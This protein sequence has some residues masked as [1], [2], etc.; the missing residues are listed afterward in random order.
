[1]VP[2]YLKGRCLHEGFRLPCDVHFDL[3]MAGRY[4]R[5]RLDKE[6]DGVHARDWCRRVDAAG[7]GV[8]RSF[9]LSNRP[10]RGYRPHQL[11][12]RNSP[13][14]T[15]SLCRPLS[16]YNNIQFGT[17]HLRQGTICPELPDDGRGIK[18]P[19]TIETRAALKATPAAPGSCESLRRGDGHVPETAGPTAIAGT[20]GREGDCKQWPKVSQQHPSRRRLRRRRRRLA[21]TRPLSE[22][23]EKAFRR[24]PRRRL[25]SRCPSW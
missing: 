13:A 23:R 6:I 14:G 8:P 12:A 3:I 16:P 17:R 1:M 9:F 11:I 15:R 10:E 2:D 25:P 22:Q 24:S 20:A 7:E 21:P 4:A 18:C 5:V 19:R